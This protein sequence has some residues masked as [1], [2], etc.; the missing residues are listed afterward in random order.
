MEA[1]DVR[2]YFQKIK[3][4]LWLDSEMARASDK[5]LSAAPLIVGTHFSPARISHI[6]GNVGGRRGFSCP[7]CEQ[8][9][10]S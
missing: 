4:N 5:I 10:P 6:N 8:R 9:L 1:A 2:L 3:K 7:A